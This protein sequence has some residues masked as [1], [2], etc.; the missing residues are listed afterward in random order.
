MQD[1]K[2]ETVDY[3]DLSKNWYFVTG[4]IRQPLR[5][6]E[7]IVFATTKKEAFEKLKPWIVEH[8][9][10]E[11]DLSLYRNNYKPEARKLVRAGKVI[12]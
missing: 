10:E 6:Y 7:T 9:I 8:S 2:L 4:T 1:N 12:K 3:I 11:D 5:H